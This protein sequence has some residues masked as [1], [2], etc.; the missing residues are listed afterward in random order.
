MRERATRPPSRSAK[1]SGSG[2]LEDGEERAA[3][4]AEI[5]EALHEPRRRPA[6]LLLARVADVRPADVLIRVVDVDEARARRICLFRDC[7]DERR[8]FLETR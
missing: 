3:V 7:V 8:V 4:V 6:E 1:S 2:F 5:L